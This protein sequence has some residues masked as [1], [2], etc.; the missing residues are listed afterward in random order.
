MPTIDVVAADGKKAGSVELDEAIFGIEPNVPVMHQ[1]VVAQE[2]AARA[3]TAKTKTRGEV[4]GGGKKPWRQKGTG[5]ARQGSIRSPQWRGGGTVFGP[6]GNQNWKQR[7][8]KKVKA[9]ALRSALSDR[10]SENNIVVLDK[11]AFDA[12]KTKD[13]IALLDSVGLSDKVVLVVIAERNL[14][15]EKSFS[16]LENVHVLTVGQLNTRDVLISDVV[17]FD[18]ASLELVGSPAPALTTEEAA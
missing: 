5:R 17:L 13:A 11:L 3:G 8:N 16:N 2:A 14:N 12:P 7:V 1:V 10:A 9:L 6:T 4:S 18:Q 15:V